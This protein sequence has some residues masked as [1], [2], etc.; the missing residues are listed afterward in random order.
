MRISGK[1]DVT[2]EAQSPAPYTPWLPARRG[3]RHLPLLLTDVGQQL[4]HLWAAPMSASNP[5][6]VA[7]GIRMLLL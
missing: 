3:Q 6:H 5:W 4:P 7:S 2:G 1:W